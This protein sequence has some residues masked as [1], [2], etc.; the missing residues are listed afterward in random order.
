[1]GAVMKKIF[2]LF[3]A[4]PLLIHCQ[5]NVWTQTNLN[6]GR[7]DA[8][9]VNDSGD[10]FA[11]GLGRGFVYRSKDLGNNWTETTLPIAFA[12]ISLEINFDGKIFVGT[13]YGIF[14]S[15]DN[16]LSY[17]NIGLQA[18]NISAIL[19]LPDGLIYAGSLGNG[20]FRSADTGHV[21]IQTGPSNLRVSGMAIHPNGNIFATNYDGG[22]YRSDS[23]G[24][25]W[26]LVGLSGSSVRDITIDTNGKIYI[27]TMITGSGQSGVFRSTDA[28]NTWDNFWPSPVYFAPHGGININTLNHIFLGTYGGVYRS[29][30]SP[31][32]V[33]INSGLTDIVYAIDVGYDGIAYAGTYIQ[34]IFRSISTISNFENENLLNHPLEFDLLQNYPN[35]FNPSTTIKYQLP[36]M[37]F[38][39]IKVFDI[40]GREVTT[41]VNEEKPA[42]SY[43]VQFTANGLSSGISARGGYASGIYFYQLKAGDY[44]ETKKMIL[45]K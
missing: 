3:L 30:G 40:L 21:W 32:W 20:I 4:I 29:T 34:G 39:V 41:L 33:L 12:V 27:C 25:S 2:F 11:G 24:N 36:E 19:L 14:V 22:V 35:P 10:V 31:N 28:G 23:G 15:S 42:G 8:I 43:E 5:T 37:S 38:V 13:D 9:A 44:N 17:A 1:M 16:G 7:F 18:E 6:E 26:E 45:L